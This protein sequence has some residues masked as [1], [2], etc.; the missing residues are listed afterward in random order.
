MKHAFIT[1]AAG[2]IGG[3]TVREFANRGWR[4]IAMVHQRT[5]GTLDAL[6]ARGAVTLLHGDITDVPG[7]EK[8]LRSALKAGEKLD[9]LVHC[10]A[11]ASDV[12]RTSV[13]RRLNFEAVRG[14]GEMAL[15]LDVGRFVFV[16]TT[17]VYGM[18]DFRGEG[19][20]ALPFARRPSNPYPVFKIEAE[21]W[22]RRRMPRDRYAIIRPAAVWGPDDPT[23]TKR[24]T[25]FLRISPVIVHF[26]KW[27]GRN[28]WPLAHVTHVAKA[29]FLASTRREAAGEAIH[30][31]D[32]EFTSTDA[33]YRILADVHFPKKKF[34]TLTLPAWLISP[35]AALVSA[36]SDRLNLD[37]PF[38]DPSAYALQV[39]S[40]NLDFDNHEFLALMRRGGMKPIS[41]EDGIRMLK[42]GDGP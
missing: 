27:R 16:S 8:A 15:R 30:V 3:E 4:V 14:L 19:E 9:A 6:A 13:F 31:L 36:I 22:I 23:L 40:S 28:R 42:G 37:H 39:V 12:G 7:I 24:V 33:F 17:D 21:K 2:F 1:G 11:R 26:G 10:A 18:K 41:R 35:L 29:L 25:D 5:S 34:W 32:S 20:A 38:M